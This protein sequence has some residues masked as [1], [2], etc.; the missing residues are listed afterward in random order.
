MVLVL[1]LHEALKEVQLTYIIGAR[2]PIEDAYS[3]QQQLSFPFVAIKCF[4]VGSDASR[5]LNINMI[6]QFSSIF[7][8]K[9][10]RT[11]LE[12]F[13]LPSFPQS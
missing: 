7:M 8:V 12:F 5:E 2:D 1:E 13:R 11:T 6:I 4:R 3:S 9:Q 10:A